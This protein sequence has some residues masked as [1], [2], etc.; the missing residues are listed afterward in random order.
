MPK[1]LLR[2]SGKW[3]RTV[4]LLML[5]LAGIALGIASRGRACD[6]SCYMLSCGS[7][8]V[9]NTQGVQ[10]DFYCSEREICL[11]E[12]GVCASSGLYCICGIC[13]LPTFC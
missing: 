1:S 2:V 13:T 11:Q 7:D 10:C 8:D 9:C 3:L 4:C 5:F 6:S 12:Y